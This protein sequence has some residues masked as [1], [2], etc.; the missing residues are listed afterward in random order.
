MKC[1]YLWEKTAYEYKGAVIKA[2]HEPA[3]YEKPATDI[4]DRTK[5]TTKI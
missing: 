4:L 3:L 2:C 5:W 1:K